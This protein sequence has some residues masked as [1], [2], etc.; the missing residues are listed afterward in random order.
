[1]QYHLSWSGGTWIRADADSPNEAR[2]GCPP[3]C[4]SKIPWKEDFMKIRQ[5]IVA[6]AIGGMLCLAADAGLTAA[7]SWSPLTVKPLMSVSLYAGPKHIVGYFLSAD[8][9]CKLTLMIAERS[10]EEKDS[11]SA[12]QASRIQVAVDVGA[13]WRRASKSRSMSARR[14]ASIRGRGRR[15]NSSASRTRKR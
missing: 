14:R 3:N 8:N 2:E 5:Q 7:E 12:A 1:M 13:T 6:T 15:C 4:S 10:D 11:S 9:R